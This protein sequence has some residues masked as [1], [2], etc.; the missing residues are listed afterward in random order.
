MEKISS[1]KLAEIVESVSLPEE[2]E[3]SGVSTNSR[4]IN[5]GDAF[6]AL[7]GEKF[8]GHDFAFDAYQN[9]AALL[10]VS[11]KIENV[12]EDR[13]VLVADTGRAYGLLGRHNRRQFKG[14][15]IALTGSA[16]KT[17]T[18]EELKFVLSQ[19]GRVYATFGNYNNYS[20]VPR[21]L[22]DLDMNADF[23]VIEM[24]MSA[25]GEIADLVSYTEP[26]MAIVTN[27]YPMH[28][29]FF[30]DF[31]AIAE[32]KA[33]IF[34]GLKKGGTA[35]INADANFADLL[36]R[37]AKENGAKVIKFGKG[38][39][40][41]F[42]FETAQPGEH[43]QYNAWCVLTVV[44]A[45]GLDVKRAEAVIPQFGALPGRGKQWR[46]REAFGEYTLI[47]DSYSGQPEAMKIAIQTLSRTEQSG[48]KIAVLG[49][50]AELGD[51]S[52][53]RH[54][55]IGQV[56]AASGIDVV[57]GVCPEMKDALA[58]LSPD[59]ERH[60]FENKDGLDDF[61]RNKLLQNNDI[62]LIKG[63]RYSSKLYQV[64]ESLIN[65]GAEKQ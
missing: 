36:E 3:I 27:V 63:A 52:K 53:A 45:L 60:Y 43:Y 33:E 46:L 48:R 54:I 19:F 5:P 10:I 8:D 35:V 30:P 39:A 31:E 9:G 28:I 59:T 1:R 6:L 12:P 26:D 47:D 57:V 64:A 51:T 29:E 7:K 61:L 14:Q 17:T 4:E 18:K 56:L 58:Q 41:R 49:K 34:R 24:G 55:E 23:A 20:G 62:V 42:D 44:E 11:R 25:K 21:T 16:G 2:T 50:M 13:Q 15:V 32:A 22:L 38:Y 65:S 37:R 40:A